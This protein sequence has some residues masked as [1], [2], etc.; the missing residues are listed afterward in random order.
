MHRL[1]HLRR[2]STGHSGPIGH[3]SLLPTFLIALCL[4]TLPPTTRADSPVSPPPA[5]APIGFDILEQLLAAHDYTSALALLQETIDPQTLSP[6]QR[7]HYAMLIGQ[8]ALASRDPAL[9]DDAITHFAEAARLAPALRDEALQAQ[10]DAKLLLGDYPAARTVYETILSRNPAPAVA[11]RARIGLG[12]LSQ[13]GGTDTPPD[14][15]SA[16]ASFFQAAHDPATPA[17]IRIEAAA[18]EI[19]ARRL[20]KSSPV[21]TEAARAAAELCFALADN[22]PTPG[23]WQQQAAWELA[24]LL[25]DREAWSDA[26][27]WM[28]RA[29]AAPGPLAERA[30]QQA[31]R[32][33]LTH[34]LWDTAQ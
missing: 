20:A 5:T 34:F 10:G 4:H 13:L 25:A 17:A 30:A 26:V 27:H 33:R 12:L 29:A 28:E 22:H 2:Q 14:H 3:S 16:A 8:A 1:F 9:M 23:H 21:N 11:A 24:R 6:S 32:W 15:A 18:R 7:A 19:H 31:E